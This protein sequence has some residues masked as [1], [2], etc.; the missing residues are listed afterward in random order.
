MSSHHIIREN[1]EPALLIIDADALSEESLGQ[2]LEWS[3]IVLTTHTN[4]DYLISRGIKIDVVFTAKPDVEVDQDGISILP[5]H[6]I[7]P[8]ALHYLTGKKQFAL[9]IL[10]NNFPADSLL[11]H[12]K[13]F[14]FAVY[15]KQF[16]YILRSTFHKWMPEGNVMKVIDAAEGYTVEN[17]KPIG[18]GAYNTIAD[19]FVNIHSRSGNTLIIGEAL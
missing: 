11:E 3:P 10:W 4:V 16:K 18:D 1:Q 6:S 14:T 15:S 17:L 5:L 7:L 13:E 8:D 9:H 19:G 2:L 12:S